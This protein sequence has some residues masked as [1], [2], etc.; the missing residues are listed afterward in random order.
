MF[1]IFIVSKFLRLK[2]RNPGL[3]MKTRRNKIESKVMNSV[4]NER[5]VNPDTEYDQV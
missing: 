3:W 1:G 5:A 4:K 2:D